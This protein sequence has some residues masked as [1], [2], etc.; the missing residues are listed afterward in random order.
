MRRHQEADA[1]TDRRAQDPFAGLAVNGNLH[2]GPVWDFG[3]LFFDELE[4]FCDGSC[5]FLVFNAPGND[6]AD[7]ALAEGNF[8]RLCP[9]AVN[10]VGDVAFIFG[11]TCSGT[12]ILRSLVFMLA[13]Y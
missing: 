12:G 5:R 8:G 1:R 4:G 13:L 9:G 7:R 2:T 11:R 6:V 10:D 3:R